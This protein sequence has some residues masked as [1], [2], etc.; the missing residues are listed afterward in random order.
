MQPINFY[1]FVHDTVAEKN[2]AQL[3]YLFFNIFTPEIASLTGRRVNVI[4]T[5]DTPGITDFNYRSYEKNYRTIDSFAEAITA[6]IKTAVTAYM[7]EHQRT[8][9]K[10]DVYIFLIDGHLMPS[11]L[12]EGLAIPEA[13]IAFATTFGRTVVAHE[14]GHLFGATHDDVALYRDTEHNNPYHCATFMATDRPDGVC[15]IF[16]Y[17]GETRAIITQHFK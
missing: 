12:V 15:A 3:E 14:V 11:M 9:K 1:T 2:D 16:G 7:T 6:D 13:N 5:R 8:A 17:S 4:F 10:N